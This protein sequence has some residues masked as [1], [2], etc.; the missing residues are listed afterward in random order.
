M[1]YVY[2]ALRHVC[3]KEKFVQKEYKNGDFFTFCNNLL[4]H[5]YRKYRFPSPKAQAIAK[6]Q[7]E[8]WRVHYFKST[9]ITLTEVIFLN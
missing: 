8:L 5:I 7:D 4:I 6:C 2:N 1:H 3:K 9:V